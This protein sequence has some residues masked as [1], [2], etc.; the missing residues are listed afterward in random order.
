MGRTEGN[1]FSQFRSAS[2]EA[3]A[4]GQWNL[5]PTILN[6]PPSNADLNPPLSNVDSPFL[7]PSGV[8]LAEGTRKFQESDGMGCALTGESKYPVAGI[9][10]AS[11]FSFN[12]SQ[13][14]PSSDQIRGPLSK[15]KSLFSRSQYSPQAS[16][17]VKPFGLD[18]ILATLE[19][20]QD[21]ANRAPLAVDW[22]A[23]AAAG[24]GPSIV[25]LIVKSPCQ[26]LMRHLM[27]AS[28]RQ[29][30]RSDVQAF[31]ARIELSPKDGRGAAYFTRLPVNCSFEMVAGARYETV[32][33]IL[34]PPERFVVAGRGLRRV[35]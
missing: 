35:A 10:P 16:Q 32:Q 12:S 8:I 24:A 3:T 21:K 14:S 1:H 2:A 7:I 11:N 29:G 22:A 25:Y 15:R 27:G 17:S 28:G 9:K 30:R 13:S 5:T 34:E 20:T 18:G 4:G 23:P 19:A 6:L 26:T 33:K 31:L